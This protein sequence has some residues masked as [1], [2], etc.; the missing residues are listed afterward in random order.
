MERGGATTKKKKKQ[1]E[2]E[3]AREGEQRKVE[4]ETR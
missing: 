1:S 2:G 3:F 4:K